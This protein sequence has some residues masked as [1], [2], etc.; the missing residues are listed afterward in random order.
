MNNALIDLNEYDLSK[1]QRKQAQILKDAYK[2]VILW[3]NKDK[4]R[5]LNPQ[6]VE[7]FSYE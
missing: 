4:L 2:K 5:L 1:K 6:E 7:V 3:K